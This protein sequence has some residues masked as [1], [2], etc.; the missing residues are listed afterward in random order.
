MTSAKVVIRYVTA[1]THV[2]ADDRDRAE[3]TLEDVTVRMSAA[4]VS[5]RTGV[6]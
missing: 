2:A 6:W 4:I 3:S 1:F 5:W